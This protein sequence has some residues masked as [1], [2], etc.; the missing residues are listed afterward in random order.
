MLR[1][2]PRAPERD[3]KSINNWHFNHDYGA[4]DKDEQQYLEHTDDLICVVQKEKTPLRKV[5]DNSLRLR[6]LPLWRYKNDI[7]VPEY[8][9]G[10]VSYYKDERMDKFASLIIVSV[11]VIMLITPIWILQSLADLNMKLVV[12]TIFVFVFLLILSYFMATKPFEALGATA[13]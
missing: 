2:Y 4:I 12:I 10:N 6:T 7:P 11:G 8:D 9:A 5:I 13:A 3:V 1:K